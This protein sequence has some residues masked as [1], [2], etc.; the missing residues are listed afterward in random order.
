MPPLPPKTN[1]KFPDPEGFGSLG[2]DLKRY[3]RLLAYWMGKGGGGH[4]P[5]PERRSL[6]QTRDPFSGE[7]GSVSAGLAKNVPLEW[8]SDIQGPRPRGMGPFMTLESSP[9]GYRTRYPSERADRINA[10]RET[11]TRN[12]NPERRRE[13]QVRFLLEALQEE[14]HPWLK[15]YEPERPKPK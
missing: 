11:A 14:T 13:D 6:P 12:K 4:V 7:V 3:L 10:L 1:L 2:S 15:G 9:E 5:G 8:L